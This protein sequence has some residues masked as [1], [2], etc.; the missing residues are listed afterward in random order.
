MT[1]FT[2]TPTDPQDAYRPTE[3]FGHTFPPGEAVTIK[4]KKGLTVEQIVEKLEGNPEFTKGS[5][6]R[7]AIADAKRQA[8]E[9]EAAEKARAEA[10]EATARAAG[11]GPTA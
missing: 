5:E 10:A 3:V 6:D 1:T 11:A 2:Y 4:A 7:Q 8:R 9:A